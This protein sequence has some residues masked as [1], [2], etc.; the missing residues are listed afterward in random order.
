MMLRH[1]ASLLGLP[2]YDIWRAYYLPA[3]P[4]MTVMFLE[5]WKL[6]I[7]NYNVIIKRT[8]ANASRDP[9]ILYLFIQDNFFIHEKRIEAETFVHPRVDVTDL[10]ES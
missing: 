2:N 4:I 8:S 6:K 3:V 10:L 9:V 7:S 1:L 5:L